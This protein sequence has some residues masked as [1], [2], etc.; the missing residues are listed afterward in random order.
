[1]LTYPSSGSP[2]SSCPTVSSL[3]AIDQWSRSCFCPIGSPRPFLDV[4]RCSQRSVLIGSK[5]YNCAERLNAPESIVRA[6]PVAYML[7]QRRAPFSTR[8]QTHGLFRTSWPSS[9]KKSLISW[10]AGTRFLVY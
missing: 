9:W 5:G 10:S 8:P 3:P 6:R 4:V 2:P 1:M 7:L